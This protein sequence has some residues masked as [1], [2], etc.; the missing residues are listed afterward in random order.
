M[1]NMNAQTRYWEGLKI[2]GIL[3]RI[4]MKD[5][6]TARSTWILQDLLG[7]GMESLQL[8]TVYAL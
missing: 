5:I 3:R 4:G 1:Q 6:C 7:R 8:V 2:S